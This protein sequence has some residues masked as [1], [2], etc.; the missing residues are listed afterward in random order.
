MSD[1]SATERKLLAILKPALE[2]V[3]YHQQVRFKSQ[4]TSSTKGSLQIRCYSNLLCSPKEFHCIMTTL[5]RRRNAFAS[6]DLVKQLPVSDRANYG[7]NT[8]P[9]DVRAQRGPQKIDNEKIAQP[10]TVRGHIRH[11]AMNWCTL[12]EAMTLMNPTTGSSHPSN[13][14]FNRLKTQA[15]AKSCSDID[16]SF[17]RNNHSRCDHDLSSLE[18]SDSSSDESIDV[19]EDIERAVTRSLFYGSAAV[20]L[21][22]GMIGKETDGYQ[23]AICLEHPGSLDLFATVSGCEHCFCFDVSNFLV[24][25]EIQTMIYIHSRLPSL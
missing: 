7:T 19:P 8:Q 20:E 17:N 11:D 3:L 23:C 2:V 21:D 18:Y 1:A 16:K 22:F 13:R 4:L 6:R 25:I 9:R 15:I 10:T 24:E 14:F 12:I 5:Y